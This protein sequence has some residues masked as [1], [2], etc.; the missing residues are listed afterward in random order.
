MSPEIHTTKEHCNH[1]GLHM[2]LLFHL[3][4]V[5]VCPLC[6]GNAF[7]LS[8]RCQHPKIWSQW[9]ALSVTS[10][11]TV[12]YMW[13]WLLMHPRF[14]LQSLKSYG[15]GCSP[16]APPFLLPMMC[17]VI[18][19]DRLVWVETSCSNTN[20]CWIIWIER[21][22]VTVTFNHFN[23]SLALRSTDILNYYGFWQI[24]TS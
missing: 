20:L 10:H 5:Q 14:G 11:K 4:F 6:H 1:Y 3:R 16:I 22:T 15:E 9:T 17:C 2:K 7:Y 13:T 24:N 12:V 23:T 8:I 18:R 19:Y 21:V